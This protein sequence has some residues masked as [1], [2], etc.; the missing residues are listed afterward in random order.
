MS[1]YRVRCGIRD[2]VSYEAFLYVIRTNIL[3]F[4][5]VSLWITRV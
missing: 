5:L 3:N 1:F 2:L 4:I